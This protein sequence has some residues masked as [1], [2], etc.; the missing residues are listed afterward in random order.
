MKK[1][2]IIIS[3]IFLCFTAIP[4]FAVDL[5]LGAATWY[6]WWEMEGDGGT[7]TMDPTFLVGPIISLGFSEQWNLSMVFLYGQFKM[8]SSGEDGDSDDINR[9][10]TDISLNYLINNYIKIF[11][12]IKAMGYYFGNGKH[13]S[14]GPALGVGLNLPIYGNYYLLG[15]LSG[16]YNYGVHDDSNDEDSGS[17]LVE[18][19]FNSTLSLAYY[20]ESAS[21]TISLG[22]RYQ[23]FRDKY[24]SEDRSDN[25]LTFYG[26]TLS[27]VYSF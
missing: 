25:D 8:E 3:V 5:N 19:G 1:L 4:L 15:N 10:D 20:L 26:V 14:I 16:M 22:G 11:G 24:E 13:H 21:T 27:V 23:F 6:A 7:N 12:G 18:F 9:I 2:I 17:N